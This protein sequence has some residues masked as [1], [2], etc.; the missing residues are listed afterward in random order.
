MTSLAS[1]PAKQ[2][3]AV[4]N[5]V[6]QRQY[7][8]DKTITPE[9][10]KEHI[11]PSNDEY[12]VDVVKAFMAETTKILSTLINKGITAQ[13]QQLTDLL[14]EQYNLTETA[15][16]NT[17]GKFMREKGGE[18]RQKMIDQARFAQNLKNVSWRLDVLK[19]D[20][21]DVVQCLALVKFE[22]VAPDGTPRETVVEMDRNE[23]EKM[24]E[25]FQNIDSKLHAFTQ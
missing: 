6:A 25:K 3:F 24:L 5:G 1:I 12:T 4:I 15:A 23:L 8:D 9:F 14:A 13:T 22:S 2:L 18:L 20:S 11:F 17:W 7:F 16:V 19:N 21:G 10:I